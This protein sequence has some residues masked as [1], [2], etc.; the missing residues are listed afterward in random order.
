MSVWVQKMLDHTGCGIFE[1]WADRCCPS[2]ELTFQ[3]K[4]LRD[5]DGV[6]VTNSPAYCL[7]VSMPQLAWKVDQWEESNIH[8][9]CWETGLVNAVLER[10][11]RFEATQH[12]GWTRLFLLWTSTSCT[13]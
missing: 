11:L 1:V 12:H 9:D 5:K 3:V 10:H 4:L 8:R 2:Q 6:Y 7:Q 13:L